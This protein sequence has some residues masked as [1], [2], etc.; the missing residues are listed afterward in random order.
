MRSADLVADILAEHHASAVDSILRLHA[1]EFPEHA[2]RYEHREVKLT[3][4]NIGDWLL[5]FAG[6]A[7]PTALVAGLAGPGWALLCAPL[8]LLFGWWRERYLQRK[9]RRLSGHGWSEASAW[10]A[11]ALAAALVAGLV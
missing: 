1:G 3:A 9:G 8:A 11:G 10:A 4:K 5:H 2:R 6:G 7:A